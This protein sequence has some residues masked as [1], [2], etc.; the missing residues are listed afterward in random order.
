MLG[1]AL[2]QKCVLRLENANWLLAI[3]PR[4][5][6]SEP[7]RDRCC[8]VPLRRPGQEAQGHQRGSLPFPNQLTGLLEKEPAHF[9]V[10]N[11]LT[12]LFNTGQPRDPGR[13][14]RQHWRPD[15]R[16]QRLL[17]ARQDEQAPHGLPVN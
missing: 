15:D 11:V 13:P 9:K 3:G 1:D 10:E 6:D 4:Q 14:R 8:Q 12:H 16:P 17:Q 5:Q 2:V 7:P